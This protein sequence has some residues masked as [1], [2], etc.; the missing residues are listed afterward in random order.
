MTE[1]T[2]TQG[3]DNN[4]FTDP[5]MCLRPSLTKVTCYRP[6]TTTNTAGGYFYSDSAGTDGT[7][8]FS[9]TNWGAS[10]VTLSTS[11][12]AQAFS[13][14]SAAQQRDIL[15]F[16]NNLAM[17]NIGGV[18]SS[19]S[20]VNH[21]GVN[22]AYGGYSKWFSVD[23]AFRSDYLAYWNAADNCA[24]LLTNL[25][26]WQGAIA[27]IY[28]RFSTVT[29][30]TGFAF[31]R[32]PLGLPTSNFVGA[33]WGDSWQ[34][35]TNGYITSHSTGTNDMTNRAYFVGG[36]AVEDR[37]L[38][39]RYSKFFD[40]TG[41][42]GNNAYPLTQDPKCT[43]SITIT[44]SCGTGKD[45]RFSIANGP[46][47]YL[48]TMIART[49]ESVAFNVGGE[50][51]NTWRAAYGAN[52]PWN[53]ALGLP[54]SEEF[55]SSGQ[56]QQNFANG[57]MNWTGTLSKI[58][59]PVLCSATC[60]TATPATSCWNSTAGT[61]ETCASVECAATCDYGSEPSDFCMSE[62]IVKSCGEFGLSKQDSNCLR[63]PT[64]VGCLPLNMA[65]Y[66]TFGI[67]NDGSAVP[68][69]P[70][71]A[72]RPWASLTG[73]VGTP[74][75]EQNNI[76]S[77]MNTSAALIGCKYNVGA[78]SPTDIDPDGTTAGAAY[79]KPYA[80]TTDASGC[81][82]VYFNRTLGCAFP[83]AKQN[84][85]ANPGIVATTANIYNKWSVVTAQMG[86]PTSLPQRATLDGSITWQRFQHG[87]VI[88]RAMDPAAYFIGG[89][90]IPSSAGD[91]LAA[92]YGAE[93]D[94][95][96]SSGRF[97]TLT[98]LALVQDTRCT[99]AALNS[100]AC[101]PGGTGLYSKTV[102]AS[103]G[104][105]KYYW[106][107]GGSDVAHA[108]MGVIGTKFLA[109]A[110]GS[111]EPNPT[112]NQY[113]VGWPVS[114]ERAIQGASVQH[115]QNGDIYLASGVAHLVAADVAL[116]YT[117]FG[118]PS[119]R[120]GVPLEDTPAP[121]AG[122]IARTQRFS[123]LKIVTHPDR[124]KNAD[125][126][127]DLGTPL[128]ITVELTHSQDF[129][130]N[131]KI[132]WTNPS[133]ATQAVLLRQVNGNGIFGAPDFV[134]IQT[135]TAAHGS[136]Q[137]LTD[138]SYAHAAKNCYVVQ[139]NDGTS[140]SPVCIYT[141]DSRNITPQRIELRI[142]VADV[143]DAGTDSSVWVSLGA[144]NMTWINTPIDDLERGSDVTY[145]LSTDHLNK[146]S[147]ISEITIANTGSDA[148]CIESIDLFVNQR[149]GANPGTFHA[150][151][152]Y[153]GNTS[154]TCRKIR[155][156]YTTPPLPGALTINHD[157]LVASS[158]FMSPN[159]NPQMQGY[160]EASFTRLLVMIAGQVL[161]DKDYKYEE[162][163]AH[164]SRVTLPNGVIPDDAIGFAFNVDFHSVFSATIYTKL[165]IR[166][167][168]TCNVPAASQKIDGGSIGADPV[169]ISTGGSGI[170]QLFDV[171][172][173]ATFAGLV[174]AEIQK[175]FDSVDDVPLDM[176]PTGNLHFCFPKT[177]GTPVT[178]GVSECEEQPDNILVSSCKTTAVTINGT[179]S[180]TVSDG[181]H[182]N[183]GGGAT[184][185]LWDYSSPPG[186]VRPTTLFMTPAPGSVF[187][188]WGG[189]C[190]G[191]PAVC[192]I[193]GFAQ[194]TV[195][196]TF[197]AAP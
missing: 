25:P 51:G 137:E 142:K 168:W 195:S 100:S 138:F 190:A 42:S 91:A 108:T 77:L 150:F 6:G 134:A 32:G 8:G 114:E 45:G 64:H 172:Y 141:P 115:F 92:R 158:D 159:L 34:R 171:F 53:G 139:L 119:G 15:R 107:V 196:A 23:T 18:P 156:T 9:G 39:A 85:P 94:S 10:I 162:T 37:A 98:P 70:N 123:K 136:V 29:G 116:A 46:S 95:Y 96:K 157:A 62:T 109:L 131:P 7:N 128:N 13:T 187:A 182:I 120:V 63:E 180:G 125:V 178:N 30:S 1:S 165:F 80:T 44:P 66:T 121:N 189:D 118:G 152:A 169:V 68:V 173:D 105:P 26:G 140:S 24:Y 106:A 135:V 57:Y 54:R 58:S 167:H 19:T 87:Y 174:N 52:Q 17:S 97:A 117:T 16:L 132:S 33:A 3:L 4:C 83:I 2:T 76:V 71:L 55:S 113:G 129:G 160:S 101:S 155:Q 183:C 126:Y 73:P 61:M 153:Y 185:C 35:F 103:D 65:N 11:A 5:G 192:N 175:E 130:D 144:F 194:P 47:G 179:G 122:T 82:A 145:A 161:H 79:Y 166:H 151:S 72:T 81:G 12:P 41:S 148:L 154:S 197:N 50:F 193:S 164:L 31:E 88:N 147:D 111:T 21:F 86:V 191:M 177:P 48:Q 40:Y 69:V 59:T 188:G 124:F 75:T 186:T 38:A 127:P 49:G 43:N 84:T 22:A 99:N 78:A 181:V 28:T 67:C 176:A 146:I 36:P 104:Y 93:F 60:P 90:L 149:E 27:N 133:A 20:I 14:L 102:N 112:L 74:G 89:A 163:P 143:P 184:A 56:T 110:S 170:L